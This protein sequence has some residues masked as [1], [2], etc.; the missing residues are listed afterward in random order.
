MFSVTRVQRIASFALIAGLSTGAGGCAGDP[1]TPVVAENPR[2][3]P[4]APKVPTEVRSFWH[5]FVY[6]PGE[7]VIAI[8]EL[9]GTTESFATSMND[10]G[11]VVG[12]MTVGTVRRAFLWSKRGG[13]IDLG[14]LPG[15]ERAYFGTYAASINA[16]GQVA[17]TSNIGSKAHAFRWSRATGMV[18]LGIPPGALHSFGQGIN[19][20]G[21]VVGQV[22]SSPDYAF[23]WT[24][25]GGMQNAGVFPAGV[26]TRAVDIND[27]GYVIGTLF[28]ENDPHSD[29]V[30][31]IAWSPSGA[32]LDIAGCAK[33]APCGL[34]FTAINVSGTVVGGESVGS[35]SFAFRWSSRDGLVRLP[36][37]Q[38]RFRSS[39]ASAIND[40]GDIAGS[41][42]DGPL[43]GAVLWTGMSEPLWIPRL[44]G[45]THS[46]ATAINNNRQ[47]AGSALIPAPGN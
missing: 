24:E 27:D 4:P 16:T 39:G 7:G 3:E 40:I 12:S 44:P 23:R 41:M 5:A 37:T 21:D 28:P 34:F 10:A 13:T 45:A 35:D 14:T 31:A 6:T 8:P 9:P 29:P 25:S 32:I 17:G 36:G 38:V 22:W 2:P 15:G 19:A 1:T 20:K 46:T 11:E 33:G 47:V 18:D 43:Y 30:G 42:S 26:S